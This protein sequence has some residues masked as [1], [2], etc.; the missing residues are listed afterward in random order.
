MFDFNI[1]T[2]LIRYQMVQFVDEHNFLLLVYVLFT[3]LGSDIRQ[4]GSAQRLSRQ[5][6]MIIHN[7]DTIRKKRKANLR[8]SVVKYSALNECT[9]V[10]THCLHLRKKY[11]LFQLIY[12]D[13][14]PR[15]F[16][17]KFDSIS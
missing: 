6:V 17:W 15:L 8:E 4:T 11:F 3:Y 2:R 12:L 13:F 7:S 1:C 14:K 10:L 5:L 16:L 9:E